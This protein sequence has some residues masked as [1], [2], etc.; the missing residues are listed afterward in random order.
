M[1]DF[2]TTFME[3]SPF[4]TGVGLRLDHIEAGTRAAVMVREGLASELEQ[5]VVND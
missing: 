3:Q 1:I 2:V 5:F 4:G